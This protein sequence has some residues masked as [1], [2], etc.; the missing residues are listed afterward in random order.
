VLRKTT[1]ASLVV[2]LSAAVLGTAVAAED[3]YYPS[4]GDPGVDVARYNLALKWK[5]KTSKLVGTAALRLRTDKGATSFQLDLHRRMAVSSV[6]VNGVAAKYT[7]DRDTLGVELPALPGASLA[8]GGPYEVV[9]KYA[10]KPRTVGEPTSRID[11][12]GL[13]WNVSGGE[14]WTMQKPY[15]AYTWY[16]V[17]DHP[18]D[19]A[20]YK[21]HLDVPSR[22]VGVSNGKLVSRTATKRRTIT[23]F[24]SDHPMASYLVTVA[25]GPYVKFTDV[26]PHGLPITYWVPKGSEDL[27]KP[28][29]K[30]PEEI[31]FLEARLGTYPF[32]TAGVIVTPGQGSVETQSLITLSR[33]N[34]RYGA[35]D[36]REQVVHRLAQAW[37]GASVTPNDWRDL[38]MSEGVGM[39]MQAKYSGKHDWKSWYFWRREFARN[40][41]YW[42]DLYGPPGA[43]NSR[44]FGQRNVTYGSANLLRVLRKK[45]GQATFDRALRSF[46]EQNADTSRGRADFIKHFDQESGQV[47]DPWFDDWLNSSTTPRS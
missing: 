12:T 6:T 3:S 15:G 25:I 28:L 10:G 22:F 33:S 18:S 2:A 19:K 35:F 26:G 39:W 14:V 4:K 41:Q 21:V 16:P 32:S 36:V 40:D 43:Y 24:S 37:Y 34:Y 9:V 47:L 30:M 29:Q 1:V 31:A 44:D 42:R 8:L 13:G 45:V 11:T 38:W 46:A 5:P 20:L 7:H 17:N 27:V 23:D